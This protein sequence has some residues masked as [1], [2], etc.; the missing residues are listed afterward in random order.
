MTNERIDAHMHVWKF[1]DVAKTWIG[2][3]RAWS[4]DFTEDDYVPLMKAA[5]ISRAILVQALESRSETQMMLA[6]AERLPW[7]A[8]VIGWVDLT[9]PDAIAE[10]ERLAAAPRAIGL[11]NW[12]MINPDPDWIASASFDAVYRAL[13]NSRLC[14][15]TLVKPENLPALLRRIDRTPGL[16]VCVNHCAYPLPEWPRTGVELRDWS[17]NM[18]ALADLGCTVKLSGFGHKW[19]NAWQPEIYDHLVEHVLNS[20]PAERVIWASNWPTLLSECSFEDWTEVSARWT[21]TI[22]DSARDSIFGNSAKRFYG[23]GDLQ[24]A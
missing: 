20:F 10:V 5:G 13:A 6:F 7:I 23:L 2:S 18:A 14:Y 4:R 22:P 21:K 17:A 1:A 3:R 11:R 9:A 15:D 19:N 16:R 12:P 24:T 8:G